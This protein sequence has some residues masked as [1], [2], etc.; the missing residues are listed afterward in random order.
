MNAPALAA[1]KSVEVVDANADA[2]VVAAVTVV[3]VRS[4]DGFDTTTV[5]VP[6]TSGS[7]RGIGRVCGPASPDQQ[8]QVHELLQRLVDD[9]RVVH[10]EHLPARTARTGKLATPLPQA[11]ADRLPP[12]LWSHQAQA[13]DLA[14]ARRSI[15]VAT[16]TA[17]GKSL[18]YQVPIAEAASDRIRGA[19][20]LIITPTKALA[21][22][23]LRALDVFDFPGVIAATYDGDS[24]TDERAWVRARA[25][26]VFTNPEMVHAGL[27]PN[28]QRWARFFSRLRFVVVDELHTLRGVFG[29]HTAH[30]LRRLRRVC[31]VY[32]ADPTFIFSSAT[33][34]EPA[35]LASELCGLTVAAVLEDGSPRG[36]RT[37][38]LLN[39]PL[40]DPA[41]GVRTSTHSEAAAVTAQLISTGLRTITFCRSRKATEHVAADIRSRLPVHMA[42]RLRS[43]RAGYLPE[44][45]REIE[46]ELSNGHA[47]GVVATTAL[48]L[49]VDIGGVD[50]CVLAGFPGTFASMW[51]QAGR[52]GR[53]AQHSVTVLVAGED[54]LD[55]WLMAHPQEL[56][57]RPPEPAV[58]NP[59][60]PFVLDPHLSCAAYEKHLSYDDA[61]YWG[62]DLDDGVRRLVLNDRLR[63][64]TRT[65]R[66]DRVEPA[67][68]WAGKGVPAPKVGLRS[69]TAGEFRIVHGDQ[70]VGTVDRSRAPS[71]VHRGAIYIHLGRAYQV[72][73]LDL[74]NHRAIVEP[75][76]GDEYT[77]PRS[78]VS[79]QVMDS[80]RNRTVGRARLHLGAIEVTTQIT[81]FQRKDTRTRRV[82]A[83]ESLDLPPT[84]LSTRGVWYIVDGDVATE[85]DIEA[86]ELLAALHATEHA[87][88]GMLP[89]FTICDRWDVGGVSIAAHPDTGGPTVFVYDGYPGGAGIAELGYAAA[90]HHLAATL[91]VID[92]CPCSAGCP[93]CVQSP[94]CGNG[95]EKLDKHAASALLQVLM[96]AT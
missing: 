73:E 88:I 95:N 24:T 90:D 4:V 14:R 39:P 48:E 19:A 20:A 84:V 40:V 12:V 86:S 57:T 51:Q 50:A 56:F 96:S 85:A 7:L 25:N 80:D 41:N 65:R 3:A 36:A 46:D 6:E 10:V 26:V 91:A 63:L 15:V 87:A 66:R 23:Q 37:F 93:S 79:I 77:Q 82:V 9:G 89:L 75:H 83:N 47:V 32:G 44:E 17:S 18:C 16:G 30:V 2:S 22:D 67:A 60:N 53:G 72:V 33:I 74:D 35:A 70:L 54:Q 68:V 42:D 92:S 27:L 21:H 29:T 13:I 49:G 61:R 55:Q 81:G 59:S 34:G 62:S 76:D 69:G 43:Y 1:A 58:I 52:A 5:D 94:K 64:R 28:H 45:R 71:L 38:A 8:A 78:H 31:A 11:I